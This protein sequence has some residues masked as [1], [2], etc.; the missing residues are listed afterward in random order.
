[1]PSSVWFEQAYRADLRSFRPLDNYQVSLRPLLAAKNILSPTSLTVLTPKN[2]PWDLWRT[3]LMQIKPITK[4]STVRKCN[5]LMNSR[6]L[7]DKLPSMPTKVFSIWRNSHHRNFV[8][9]LT[10]WSR[11]YAS[12]QWSYVSYAKQSAV[13]F[14]SGF[15]HVQFNWLYFYGPGRVRG[16]IFGTWA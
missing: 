2:Y 7:L 15:W 10:F 4:H 6:T 12:S 9:D 13:N 14:Y 8:K 3:T 5:N 16:W 1:M 11:N